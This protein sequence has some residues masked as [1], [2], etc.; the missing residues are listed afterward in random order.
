MLRKISLGLAL[1][2]LLVGLASCST[3]EPEDPKLLYLS[4]FF[5]G[6]EVNYAEASRDYDWYIDQAKTG[7]YSHSNC[8]PSSVVMAMKWL[9]KDFQG[10]AEEARE[11]HFL[12]GGWWYTSIVS[13]YFSD[14]EVGLNYLRL[15]NNIEETTKSLKEAID[16]GKIALMCL[17][18]D[19]ISKGK[20]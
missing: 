9:D 20:S 2:L 8:G 12:N 1:I 13:K 18:M 11:E 5:E 14:R 6:E 16:E 15:D 3:Q 4:S 17:N 7:P 10:T 19:Y